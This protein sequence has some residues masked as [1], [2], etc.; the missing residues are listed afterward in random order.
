MSRFFIFMIAVGIL[1]SNHLI[2][3]EKY[4]IMEKEFQI[5]SERFEINIDIG[6]SKLIVSKGEKGNVCY[7]YVKYKKDK[8]DTDIY[9]DEKK[10]KLNIYID[11][12]IFKEDDHDYNNDNHS[13][14]LA[15][16]VLELPCNPQIDIKAKVKAGE[17]SFL[18]GDITLN[19]FE[20]KNWAGEVDIDFD[21]P[22]R[23]VLEYFDLNC[24]IGELKIRNFG[25][26]HCKE[27]DIDG[28]IGEMSLDFRGDRTTGTS[29]VID[30]DLG[31]TSIIIPEN[32]NTKMKVAKFLFLSNIEYP[33]WF[34]K[35]GNYYYSRDYIETENALYL[36]ISTGIGDLEIQLRE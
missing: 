36:D 19:S 6:L 17:I 27:A 29:A 2:A 11:N 22:N 13:S 20:L 25:N 10:G 33:D 3:H 4:E 16:I 35:R 7:L 5:D 30:L 28:G 18:L 24:K 1:Y 23:T 21:Q 26:A 32:V 9:F 12:G 14:D 34:K 15:K 8:S 31:N